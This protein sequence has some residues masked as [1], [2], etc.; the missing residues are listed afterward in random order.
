PLRGVLL[1]VDG[2]LAKDSAR[3]GPGLERTVEV[4]EGSGRGNVLARGACRDPVPNT[5]SGDNG[6]RAKIDSVVTLQDG[7]YAGAIDCDGTDFRVGERCVRPRR[8]AQSRHEP[9]ETGGAS[10][11]DDPIVLIHGVLYPSVAGCCIRV[12]FALARWPAV[13]EAVYRVERSHWAP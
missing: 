13:A 10:R 12:P 3:A 7:I 8:L 5:L 9:E 6:R 1:P 4:V 11:Q 2:R